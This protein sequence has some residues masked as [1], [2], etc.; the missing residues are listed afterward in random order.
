[1]APKARTWRRP[2]LLAGGGLVVLAALV[3]ALAGSDPNPRPEAPKASVGSWA[4]VPD[5][6]AI[7]GTTVVVPLGEGKVL[8]AGGGVSAIPLSA[9]EIYDVAGGGWRRT[10]DLTQA[11]RGHQGVVLQDGRVLVVGGIAEGELLASAET[12]DP[13]AGVWQPTNPMTTARL[14]HSLTVLGDGRVLAAGGTTPKAQ[15]A[16]VGGQTI[17]ADSSAEIYDPATGQWTAATPM[18]SARFE[19][20]ATLLD[21]GRVLIVGGLGA[22]TGESAVSPLGTAEL[23]DPAAGVF[24][25]SGRMAEG[26]TNHAS[27]RLLDGSVVVIGGAGGAAGD[28]SLASAER[29]DP[30]RGT[31]VRVEAMSQPRSGASATLLTGGRVLVAGGEAVERGVRRSLATSELFDPAGTWRPAGKAGKMACPRSEQAAVALPGGVVLVVAGDAS[32]PGEPPIA[33]GCAEL[34]RP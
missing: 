22:P 8:A 14:G 6:A 23:Y 19:H 34:Y 2:A 25:G 24:V 33:Q 7:R 29:Y 10:G 27:V 4:A 11:R 30:R 26:R 31:W 1:M 20:T 18:G 15:Q 12:Y 28:V 9:A 32:F 3:F 17:R 21:D 16:S 13:A 5:L